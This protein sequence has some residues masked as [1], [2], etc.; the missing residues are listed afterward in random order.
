MTDFCSTAPWPTHCLHALR[1]ILLN[2][3]HDLVIGWIE[4]HV[5]DQE[6]SWNSLAIAI[7]SLGSEVQA[8]MARQAGALLGETVI[9]T[10]S[11]DESLSQTDRDCEL[12][13]SMTLN[14]DFPGITGAMA[15]IRER[16]DE[17]DLIAAL[18][19]HATAMLQI[20]AR[21]TGGR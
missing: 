5:D 7:A 10:P 13:V 20:Q 19:Q 16:G 8:R 4:D 11:R 9:F 12:I 21:A 3:D 18:V 17:N 14:R 2:G 6:M 1:G 15:G